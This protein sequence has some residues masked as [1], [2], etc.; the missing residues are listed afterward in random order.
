[1]AFQHSLKTTF[2]MRLVHGD[3]QHGTEGPRR[4]R[5]EG[6]Q[7]WLVL[8][9]H[10]AQGTPGYGCETGQICAALMAHQDKGDGE[11]LPDFLDQIPAGVA[12]D[13]IDGDGAYDTKACHA[14]IAAHVAACRFR[15]VRERRRGQ[16]AR[17]G[18]MLPSTQSQKAAGANGS[19]RLATTGTR[20]S[21][22]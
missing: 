9:S 16:P 22:L 19:R 21:R 13:T 10:V 8:T 12:I 7:A 20:W 1:M 15:P 11:V 18:A 4:R 14:Q 5:V 17:L 6:T 2:L 3:R